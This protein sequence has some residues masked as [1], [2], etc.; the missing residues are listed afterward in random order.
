MYASWASAATALP[1]GAPPHCDTHLDWSATGGGSASALS[2]CDG[3]VAVSATFVRAPSVVRVVHQLQLGGELSPA[4]VVEPLAIT[5]TDATVACVSVNGDTEQRI[6][7]GATW[8][9]RLLG[10]MACS[11]ISSVSSCN[12]FTLQLRSL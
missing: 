7:D 6:A 3:R 11:L 8:S 1:L 5:P 4:A 12:S 9:R 10:V 2:V